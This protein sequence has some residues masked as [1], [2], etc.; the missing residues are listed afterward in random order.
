MHKKF[1]EETSH[2]SENWRCIGFYFEWIYTNE[3]RI[4]TLSSAICDSIYSQGNNEREPGTAQRFEN[5]GL[6]MDE[7]E[8]KWGTEKIFWDHNPNSVGEC[9][10]QNRLSSRLASKKAYL[11]WI[12]VTNLT[13]SKGELRL[14]F[15]PPPLATSLI[16]SNRTSSFAGVRIL[17]VVSCRASI[18]NYGLS[19]T[20]T[21]ALAVRTLDPV[22]STSESNVH[23]NE[24]SIWVWF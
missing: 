7:R 15:L 4:K 23:S 6:N 14:P 1:L 10:F 9:P 2:E 12:A 21:T 20:V 17:E 3:K 22:C 8:L 11:K 19:E 16:Q 24:F 5:Q 13:F 18:E